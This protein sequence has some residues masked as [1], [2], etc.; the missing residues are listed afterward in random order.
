MAKTPKDRARIMANMTVKEVREG[1]RKCQTVILPIGCVEQHGYHMPLSVDMHN[2]SELAARTAARTG[3]FV[4]P[5]LYYNY[6]GGELPG[7]INVNPHVVALFVA[8]ICGALAR[9]GFK[10]IFV[11][12]GHGG[13][14]SVGCIDSSVD[15]FLRQNPQHRD[16]AVSVV[17]FWELC[18]K[19]A[20]AFEEKD[21][22]AGYVETSLMMYWKPELVRP[23]I[24]MD[25]PW[26]VE[27]MREHQDNYQQRSKPV[28]H[29]DVAPH[30]S[31]HPDIEVGVM[32]YPERASAK[33]GK[34]LC[35]EAVSKA[36]K[37]IRDI[38]KQRR[39]K[40]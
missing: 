20:Q 28:D 16:V 4:A 40:R 13:T 7:T 2:A 5:T 15:I 23:K 11:F 14:E 19:I 31:Q 10:N 26:L 1:L 18:D 34:D 6:S 38:E 29:P 37:L 33:F 12:L 36:A 27:H 8:E 30:I 17:K 24:V 39:E 25:K 21:Y 35:E 32:G 22:H 3:S 9:Q